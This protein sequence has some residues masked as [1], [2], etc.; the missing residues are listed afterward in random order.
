MRFLTLILL[1]VFRITSAS[2]QTHCDFAIDTFGII[3]NHNLRP[4]IDSLKAN[5]LV[6][7]KKKKF[8]PP[9]IKQ[10]LNCWA[11]GFAI[12]NPGIHYSVSG[13]HP[14]TPGNG[15]GYNQLGLPA[16]QLIY[17]GFNKSLVLISYH[18]PA[19]QESQVL[20][21]RHNNKEVLDFWTSSVTGTG[22]S[23]KDEIIT[24]LQSIVSTS[25]AGG[26][27]L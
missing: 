15:Y 17:L 25:Q 1:L 16:R 4:L 3:A 6:T 13:D 9:V 19:K 2:S 27:S 22:L 7:Y 26:I 14:S 5:D 11:N 21:F 10:T 18:K 20:I 23:N 8:I 24:Y 12:A